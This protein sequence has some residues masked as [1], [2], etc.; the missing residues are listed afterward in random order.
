MHFEQ[1]LDMQKPW[2][3][4]AS[5]AM[6]LTFFTLACLLI[7]DATAPASATPP[8][9]GPSYQAAN[10]Q[11]SSNAAEAAQTPTEQTPAAQIPA[12]QALGEQAPRGPVALNHNPEKPTAD[13]IIVSEQRTFKARR[14]LETIDSRELLRRAAIPPNIL[15]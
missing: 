12:E 15:K 11:V 10:E 4:I 3:P 9:A 1:R 14:A 13:K 6:I 7:R 5:L 2:V 8:E